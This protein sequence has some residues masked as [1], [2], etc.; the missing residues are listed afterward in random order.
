MTLEAPRAGSSLAEQPLHSVSQ[1]GG[2]RGFANG[3][4]HRS[5]R[6]ALS[7]DRLQI[8]GS[9]DPPGR[10]SH[11]KPMSLMPQRCEGRARLRDVRPRD[12]RGRAA[13]SQAREAHREPKGARGHVRA[14]E[15][16]AGQQGPGC[17][18][19]RGQWNGTCRGSRTWDGC[20]GW[21]RVERMQSGL[22]WPNLVVTP[23]KA[24]SQGGQSP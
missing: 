12:G 4:C 16:R 5:Q 19:C 17:E 9:E 1:S 14:W 7:G 15:P 2:L 3:L 21:S 20:H 10:L 11:Q 23:K 6:Q 8:K 13:T 18:G 22:L 24:C